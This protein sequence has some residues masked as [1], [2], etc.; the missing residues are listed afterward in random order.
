VEAFKHFDGDG[1]V[2]A[3]T[4]YHTKE[5]G[6]TEDP[7]RKLLLVSYDTA[8]LIQFRSACIARTFTRRSFVQQLAQM[9]PAHLAPF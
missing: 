6:L 4:P 3:L 2:L 7:V 8:R 1:N 9:D 5:R